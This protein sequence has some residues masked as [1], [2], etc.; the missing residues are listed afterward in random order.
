MIVPTPSGMLDNKS[1]SKR[2]YRQNCPLA[3]ALDIV[4]ERWT[5]LILR[6]LSYGPQRYNQMLERF[7][8]IGTNLLAA[9]LKDLTAA[10][11]IRHRRQGPAATGT[12]YELTA[13][14]QELLPAL[15]MLARWGSRHATSRV[16]EVRPTVRWGIFALTARHR[17]QVAKRTRLVAEFRFAG[18]AHTIRVDR[19]R[20]DSAPSAAETPDV[21]V[22]GEQSAF[23]DVAYGRRALDEAIV[24][25]KL[26]IEGDRSAVRSFVAVFGLNEKLAA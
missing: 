7:R 6:E 22:T 17:P 21:R 23:L 15:F 5:L 20:V 18:S 2:K 25:R 13:T 14:G 8:G 19:G 9:R 4:G 1:V 26:K 24:A 12:V 3:C 16:S 11:I 10:R